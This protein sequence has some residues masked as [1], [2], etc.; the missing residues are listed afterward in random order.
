MKKVGLAI[1]GI[2][3]FISLLSIVNIGAR[4]YRGRNDV[5]RYEERMGR[6]RSGWMMDDYDD[7]GWMMRDFND[8]GWMM[9]RSGSRYLDDDGMRYNTRGYSR[10]YGL[11]HD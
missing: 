2:I 5:Y 3:A 11:C 8:S 10:G 1:L 6:G 4:E 7:S 9:G